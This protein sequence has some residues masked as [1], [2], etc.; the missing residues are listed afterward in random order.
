MKKYLLLLPLI[1]FA[2]LSFAQQKQATPC[3]DSL[4]IQLQGD[5]NE[6]K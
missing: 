5:I 2:A 3:N 6:R 4:F 1:L